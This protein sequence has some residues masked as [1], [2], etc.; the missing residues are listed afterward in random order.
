MIDTVK[1]DIAVIL[2][3]EEINQVS[4]SEVKKMMM[5]GIVTC[6]LFNKHDDTQPRL[7]YKYKEDDPQRAWLKVELSVPRYLYGSNVYEFKQADVK[8]MLRQLR[9]YVVKML[10]LP[11]FRVPHYNDW[12][13][14][15]LHICKNFNVG[16]HIQDYL[17]LLSSMQ[18]PGGYKTVPYNAAGSNRLESVYYQRKGKR[19]R[20]IHKFYD[21]RAEVDQKSLY[22]NK[23]QHQQDAIGLLRYEIELTYDEM[24]KYSFTRRATELIT[25]QV[26]VHVLQEG[27]SSLGLTKPI[28]HSPFD[29][30]LDTINSAAF[31]VRTQAMLVA[32]LTHL[33]SYGQG[34]CKQ[35]YT[36]TTYYDNYNKL[37]ELFKMDVIQF[38]ET[39][40]PPLKI[41]NDSFKNKKSRSTSVPA[42]ETTTK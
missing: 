38:A 24:R 8:P 31:N 41:H 23:A 19:N 34:Y 16:S 33:H 22:P 11:L 26:A 15:K 2:T 6:E 3:E 27:L 39:D 25:P 37:K 30:M 14:E 20:S 40:L 32:F 36:K 42:G 21:K 12:E 13:V 9:R 7:F 28:K 17:K 18:K 5:S 10:K 1:F 35:K 4:W 29:S